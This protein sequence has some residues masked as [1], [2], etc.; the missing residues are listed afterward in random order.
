MCELPLADNLTETSAQPLGPHFVR[1]VRAW[2]DRPNSP[3]SS[4][5]CCCCSPQFDFDRV[6]PAPIWRPAGMWRL[7]LWLRP[8]VTPR[9]S[10]RGSDLPVGV[11]GVSLRSVVR[12][13]P[14]CDSEIPS[15]PPPP[16]FG[17][18]CFNEGFQLVLGCTCHPSCGSCGFGAWPSRDADCIT[19][20]HGGSVLP[21]YTDRTGYCFETF[22]EAIEQ[23]RVAC[24]A[25][26]ATAV[27]AVTAVTT[28]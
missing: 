22:E 9:V 11:S 5:V 27:T 10:H 23:S 7:V 14:P 16:N 3:L 6:R 24:C 13:A 19:C 25:P 2:C 21:L 1:F 12:R 20:R 8:S 26:A 15:P 28:V 17:S 4:C 18:R